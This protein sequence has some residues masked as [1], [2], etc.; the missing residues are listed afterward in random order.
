MKDKPAFYLEMMKKLKEQGGV[1]RE[2]IQENELQRAKDKARLSAQYERLDPHNVKQVIGGQRDI[3]KVFKAEDAA[4]KIPSSAPS[5]PVKQLDNTKLYNK[6]GKLINISEAVGKRGLKSL[7]IIGAGLGIADAVKAA[8]EGDYKKAGLEAL[9]A[10]D[11]TP[12]SDLYLAG[13]DIVD[14]LKQEKSPVKQQQQKELQEIVKPLVKEVGGE[15][16]IRPE[17]AIKMVGEKETE[18]MDQDM[19]L[20]R[21]NYE[22]MLKRRLGYYK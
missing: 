6:L 8:S 21:E 12:I 5:V 9:S 11:P 7:P 19:E 13:Q 2:D 10:I 3:E 17:K 15:P 14:I 16:D 20:T 4:K 1:I 22:K 18:D